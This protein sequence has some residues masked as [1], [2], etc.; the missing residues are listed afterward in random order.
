M[1]RVPGGRIN[2][3]TVPMFSS[4]PSRGRATPPAPLKGG[5]LVEGV[6]Q[7]AHASMHRGNRLVVV[8]EL[9]LL[10]GKDETAGS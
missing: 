5:R 7:R 10:E 8:A 3:A 9:A 2:V 1:E 4:T 6:R